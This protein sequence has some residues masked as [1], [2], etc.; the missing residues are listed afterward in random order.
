[1]FGLLRLKVPTRAA[2]GAGLYHHRCISSSNHFA[3][4][5]PPVGILPKS[6]LDDT[7]GLPALPTDRI[8]RAVDGRW[9]K[10]KHLVC[11]DLVLRG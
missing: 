9:G 6:R 2:A 4:Q 8:G 3:E 11:C 5:R 7:I 10:K 1:M